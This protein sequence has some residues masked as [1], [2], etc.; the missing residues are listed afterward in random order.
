MTARPAECEPSCGVN[1][2]CVKQEGK[3][4]CVCDDGYDGN[5]V[6]CFGTSPLLFIPLQEYT[7]AEGFLTNAACSLLNVL[8]LWQKRDLVSSQ[9]KQS[10]SIFFS[11]L[12]VAINQA[13]WFYFGFCSNS[14]FLENV[15]QTAK[16]L[17]NKLRVPQRVWFFTWATNVLCLSLD[18]DECSD[19][20]FSCP[21]NTVC[22]NT[23]GSYRCT[24]KAG[25]TR[26]GE[27]CEG[28]CFLGRRQRYLVDVVGWLFCSSW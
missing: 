12:F 3:S 20:A 26:L 2:R 5:G 19:V 15:F 18:V 10:Q 28:E 4:F 9:I 23:D 1:A 14:F 24:C 17:R 7:C 16:Q 21:S 25:Y 27:R 6:E 13:F 11:W 8:H 22:V